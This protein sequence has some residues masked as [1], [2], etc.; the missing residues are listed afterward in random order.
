VDYDTALKNVKT[1]KSLQS[2]SIE[3]YLYVCNL[4]R[5]LT[6]LGYSFVFLDYA[7]PARPLRSQHFDIKPYLPEALAQRYAAWFAP[8]TDIYT[9]CLKR[10]QLGDDDFHPTPAG[11]L[12]WVD[13][14]LLPYLDQMQ[15]H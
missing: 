10:D 6:C 3:N 11:H 7:D 2:R 4:A 1:L 9:W 15:S 5:Y 14:V 12:A 8:V 13:H